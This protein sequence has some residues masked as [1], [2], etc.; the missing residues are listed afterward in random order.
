MSHPLDSVLQAQKHGEAVGIPSIRSAHPWVL[1]TALQGEGLV[2]IES[3]C[4]QVNQE[5]GTPG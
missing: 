1:K 3:T 4:N 2:L 5:G